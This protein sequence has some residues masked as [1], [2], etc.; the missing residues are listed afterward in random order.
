[1]KDTAIRKEMENFY[2]RDLKMNEKKRSQSGKFGVSTRSTTSDQ[3]PKCF[4]DIMDLVLHLSDEEWRA[5]SRGMR[6]QITRVEF[7][8]VC[9]KIVTEVSSAIVRRLLK[10]LSRSFGIE[11]I[12][13]ANKKLKEME[14]ESGKCS[15]S[16]AS[17][18]RSPME[19]SDLICH[20]AQRVVTEIKGAM[21]EAIRSTA[22][23]PSASPPAEDPITQLD[24]LSTA[25]T[26]EI[27][28]KILGVYHSVEKNRLT[29]QMCYSMSLTSLLKVH[30]IMMGLED[31]VS[32]SR[33]SS[34][35]T[36]STTSDSVSTKTEVM[37]PDSV[38]SPPQV[39]CPFS[40]QFMNTAT[41]L[42]TE[43]LLKMEQKPA[44]SVSS[45][46]SVPASSETEL[47]LELAKSTATEILHR[48]YYVIHSC[49]YADQSVPEHV[50]FLSF[51]QKIHADIHKR[52]F[53]FVC[54]RKEA[55][56]DKSKTFL[57]ACTETDA[58]LNISSDNVQKNAAAKEILDKATQV[59]SEILVRRLTSQISTGLI[60]VTGS[61]SGT[62]VD[63]DRV[64]SG[65]VKKVI[66]GVPLEI[67]IS[68]VQ[69]RS[70]HLRQSSSDF[71]SNLQSRSGLSESVIDE[72][73][74]PLPSVQN[75]LYA[76]LHIF[77]VVRD[78]LRSFFKSFSKSAADNEKSID[79]S[80]YSES[81]EDSVVPIYI[82]RDGS[83]H[84]LE[85]GQSLSDSV[86]ERRNRM[87]LSMQFPSELI[88]TFVEESIKA[89][90]Q[91]VLNTGS[92]E[93]RDGRSTHT[94]EDQQK[95]KKPRVHF[96]VKTQRRVV[97][98]HPRKQKK[99]RRVPLPKADQPSTSTSANLHEASHRGSKTLRSVFK[100]ARRTLGRFFSN[101]SKTFT[102]S[103]SPETTP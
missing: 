72:E 34:W 93:G 68:E 54:E 62:A 88:Y 10:P 46:T 14:S 99:Q 60:S 50:K 81:V 31:A 12:H 18:Q 47:N 78:Q 53:T 15:A 35:I 67:G 22:S 101:I 17:V 74:N 96:V 90:L 79:M 13:E 42:I 37:I 59:A 24:D 38:S 27:C 56:S 1:M 44:S 9:T 80:A 33:S 100:S 84:K 91:N 2:T 11:A 52:V 94:A 8:A 65:S 55:A 30:K 41:Q 36:E 25:C 73:R 57:D 61:G 71:S 49:S 3:R 23:E 98:K 97:V 89:L 66:S 28:D 5:V 20:V 76:P 103:V 82:S 29:E 19:A 40:D 75:S 69:N 92:S 87:L 95:K 16:G 4:A 102:R 70:E 48:L 58:E 64:A 7:V 63:L 32:I 51:A 86:L 85:V 6:K 77:T 26:N 39:Q 21:L 45:Q 43:V 83:V